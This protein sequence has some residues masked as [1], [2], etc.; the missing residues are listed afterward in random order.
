MISRETLLRGAGLSLGHLGLTLILVGYV[1]GRSMSRFDTGT[2]PQGFEALIENA[3]GLVAQFLMNPGI[4]VYETAPSGLR[5]N[6]L[7]WSLM[8]LNSGVWGFGLL[9]LWRQV[10]RR[11]IST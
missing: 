10:Q 5:T 2:L 3:A 9:F 8:I 11:I 1:F 6:L 7:E 4:F